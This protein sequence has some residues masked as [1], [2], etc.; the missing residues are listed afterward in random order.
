MESAHNM[1][2]REGLNE[3]KESTEF[4]ISESQ[5]QTLY[6]GTES[7]LILVINSKLMVRPHPEVP[8]TKDHGH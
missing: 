8:Q 7:R 4:G 6:K 2:T 3:G 1:R 5:N